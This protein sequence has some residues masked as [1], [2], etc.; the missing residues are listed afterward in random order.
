[1]TACVN[2]KS[3]RVAAVVTASLVGAL[4][5]GAP[6]V[7]LATTDTGIDMLIASQADAFSRG[8]I[9]LSGSVTK[10]SRNVYTATANANGE[11]LKITV[12]SVTPLGTYAADKS[13]Y[14]TAIYK[15][16]EDGNKTGAAISAV[17]EPGKYVVEVTAVSGQYKGAVVTAS[18]NVKGAKLENLSPYEVSASDATDTTD[19]SFTYTGSA[20]SVGFAANHVPYDEG[21]DYSVKILKKGT[22]NVSTAP[23][24]D[25]V[26][27]GDYVAYITGLGQYAGEKLEVPFTVTTFSFAHATIEV[28]DVI[29]TDSAPAHPTKVFVGEG[30]TYAELD[31]SL[32]ALTFA[33]GDDT[34]LF[35]KNGA[36]TFTASVDKDNKNIVNNDDKTVKVNKVA[37]AA[38][39]KVN[40][41]DV[42]DSYLIDLSDDDEFIT[43][44]DKFNWDSISVHNGEK[45]LAKGTNYT[46]TVCDAAGVPGQYS[47]LE[48]LK[49]GTY[50]VTV[51][52]NAS[53]VEYQ[54]GG[55]VTFKVQVVEGKIDADASAFVYLNST[56]EDI[57]LTSYTKNYDGKRVYPTDFMVKLF[58]KDNQPITDNSLTWKLVD[59]NGKD[60]SKTGALRAGEYKLVI[61]S[62]NYLLSG[63]TELPVTINKVDLSTIKV[64]GLKEW[65]GANYLPINPADADGYAWADFDLRYDTHIADSDDDDLYN[66]GEG[67]DR[68][69]MLP[70][71]IQSDTHLQCQF[72]DT[73]AEKWV[74]VDWGNRAKAEGKYRI[75]LT[76]NRDL[77]LNYD[78]ANDDYTT[79]VEF[80]AVIADKIMFNDVNPDDWFFDVVFQ[81]KANGWMSGYAS[82]KVFGAED[83]ITRGQVACVLY[84]MAST[85]GKADENDL[86]YN[87]VVGW[88]TGFSDVN[89]K[90]Y[91]GKAVAWA[92]QAGIVNGYG[93]GTF[94]PDAAVT[95]EELAC[96]LANFAKKIDQVDV[97]VKDADEVLSSMSDGSTVS[98]WAK[99]NVAW[100]VSEKVMGNAGS[101]NPSADIIRAEV[102]AMIVNYS[103]ID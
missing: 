32:V 87:E 44:S 91:Y 51:K 14:E 103:E 35:D 67:W 54:A 77:A 97:S 37:K 41:T 61:S 16:D 73:D 100:A 68:L 43:S 78:F 53:S 66:D 58:D 74:D 80:N 71:S 2:K 20:L 64:G 60:I 36:Y 70:D 13:E 90:A 27:A 69:S 33:S 47:N 6:A 10:A 56:S 21:I 26:A 76:G 29:G 12:D 7:A 49:A 84:N 17:V 9:A 42:E 96:M 63:T 22:D 19:D 18:V 39:F 3:K 5:I 93:D 28:D 72:W 46:I 102:A 50:L 11:A 79:V 83:S 45:K 8:E 95:R 94:A 23:G 25:V 55:S 88:D 82:S 48:N 57:V 101:V 52:V 30:E 15:A 99:G 81:A 65:Y 34:D 62:T 59:S 4:S 1:M 24:V 38:T 89:G 98:D 92:K 31:S 86:S 75:V 40:K 85:A